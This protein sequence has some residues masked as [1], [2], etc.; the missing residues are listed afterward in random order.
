[1]NSTLSEDQVLAEAELLDEAEH[2]R[3]QIRQSSTIHPDMTL[4]DAYRIQGAWCDLKVA[5]GERVV[6]H[7]IGLTSRAMQMAMNITTPDS[8][9]ITDRMV[10]LPEQELRAADF[11][12]PKIE[13]ELAFVL[14][15]DLRGPDLGVEDV[16]D[17]TDYVTPA[18]ELLAARSHR[19]DP[20]T[21]RS[22]T[23]IDTISD[24]A[25]DAGIIC[26][27]RK[28]KPRDV[29]LRWVC[30]LAYR[31]GV[32]EETGVA[33]A[34]LDHP[35]EGVAWLARR[36]DEQGLALEAGQTILAGSFIRPIDVRAGDDFLLDFHDLGSFEMRFI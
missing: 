12:D 23:V 20:E 4:D 30:A 33:A 11:L 15:E 7:K 3:V 27:G 17:A 29:D 2:S 19:R 26:G 28:V 34:V 31:N 25:A 8:G 24:N 32:I 5:R 18:V 22:R 16:L 14:V 6:G 10:F 21:G 9:F 35:A 13:V 1:V 36:Y